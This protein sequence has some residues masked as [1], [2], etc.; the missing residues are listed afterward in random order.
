MQ[1]PFS[2]MFSRR[3]RRFAATLCLSALAV[4]LALPVTHVAHEASHLSFET[5]TVEQTAWRSHSL[6]DDHGARHDAATC[7]VCRTVSQLKSLALS[8]EAV[9]QPAPTTAWRHAQARRIDP[10]RRVESE[11]AP[12]GPPAL[13]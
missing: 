10:S 9:H 5:A 12:R 8:R 3:F 2:S 6:F 1:T 13:A 11:A 4:Q 7:P